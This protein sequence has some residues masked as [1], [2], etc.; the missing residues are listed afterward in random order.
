M[1]WRVA[2]TIGLWIAAG[3][4]AAQ[5][6]GSAFTHQGR[7]LDAGSPASGPYDFRCIL[8]DAAAGGSQVGPIVTLDDVAV[9]DGLF[10][11]GLDFGAGAFRG[12]ARWLEIAVR[13]GTSTG[14]YTVVGSRQE[15]KPAPHALWSAAADSTPWTGVTGK[16]AGFADNVDNDSGGTV[17]GVATGA[18]LTGGPITSSGT[19]AVANGG[20][21]SALL[22]DG[23]VTSA[24]I[25][26]GAVGASQINQ[27]QVQTRIGG[28][29]PLGSYLRG[30]NPDG[31]VVC[32]ALLNPHAI[33]TVYDPQTHAAG[34]DVAIAIA[35]D[36]RPVVSHYGTINSG[37]LQV[38]KCGN[39]TCS[40]G[41]T[42]RTPDDS[43]Q[44]DVG[45]DS[46]IAIGSDGFP[47]VSYHD[48]TLGTLK[49]LKC[50]DPTCTGNNIVTTVDDHPVNTV[51]AH[52]SIAIG[53][54]GFP[55][56]SYHDET[57]GGLKVAKCVNVNC[58]GLNVITTVDNPSNDVG[59]DTSIAIGADGLPVISYRDASAGTLKVAK[60]NSAACNTGANITTVASGAGGG[61]GRMTIPADGRPIV[62]YEAP[63]SQS[64]T[65]R[66]VKCG[67]AACSA[68]NVSNEVYFASGLGGANSAIAIAADGLPILS[69]WAPALSIAKCGDAACASGNQVSVLDSPPGAGVGN[70]NAIA[71]GPDGLPVVA[72]YDST[73]QSLKVAKCG[74]TTCQ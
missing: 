35:P 46:A 66:V 12:N 23:A 49:V 32:A 45:R 21:T 7:L 1:G 43:S 10:T 48:A 64:S 31:T 60:C 24:K 41:N 54:D 15:V 2:L 27:A 25:A 4:L 61:R 50:S 73:N 3:P 58:T 68:G 72:Y 56:I 40:A 37:A 18:G 51:G 17:T 16:P 22:A 36:G 6:V 52:T 42:T 55:V 63:I 28:T 34:Q 65:I 44:N 69:H 71:V 29:C 13:P 53:T 47:V 57:A 9:A 59:L 39:A 67:N 20:I 19:I 5:G 38:T 33:G 14:A 26:N 62:S 8:Y 70:Y 74:N 30:I 11:I